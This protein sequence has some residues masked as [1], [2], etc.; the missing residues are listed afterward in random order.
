M[1]R[2]MTEADRKLTHYDV[3]NIK[4]QK[5]DKDKEKE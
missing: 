4:R 2:G 3:Y 1:K 5:E